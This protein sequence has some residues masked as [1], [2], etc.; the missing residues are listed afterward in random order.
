MDNTKI[1]FVVTWLDSNDPEWQKDYS[2]YKGDDSQADTGRAR[3]REWDLFHFW[4]RAVEQ[5]A[6]WV[7]KVFL[8]TNGTFPKWINPNHPKLVLVKHEDYIPHEL[9]PTFNSRTIELYMHKIPGLSEHFVYFN[10]DCYLNQPVKPSYYFRKGLP[11][12]RNKETV[13]NVAR[14]TPEDRYNTFLS[15][16]ASVSVVNGHF[17]RPAVISKSLRRWFGPHLGFSGVLISLLVTCYRFERFVGFKT[18]HVEQPY[19]KTIFEDA[20]K[21]EPEL[22]RSSCTRFR[23]ESSLTIYFFRYWQFASNKFYPVNL[24]GINKIQIR[25]ENVHRMAE[26]LHNK[27]TKSLCLNDCHFCTD[28]DFVPIQRVLKE[29]FEKKFPV[30]SAYEL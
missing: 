26:A 29:E 25:K 13:F 30:K 23:E 28:N 14:Y 3:F 10:D 4:F 5:Y 16:L 21:A 19:L 1:D 9:L 15:L 18:R 17:R 2:R 6:P 20:W 24:H 8:V 7:N 11:C 27:K 22:L 12:D